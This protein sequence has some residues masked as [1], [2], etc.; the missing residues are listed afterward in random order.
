MNAES[1]REHSIGPVASFL[2]L[3]AGAFVGGATY[4][5]HCA[6]PV[7]LPSGK[8]MQTTDVLLHFVQTL[9][10]KH[11][12][13][14]CVSN[15]HLCAESQDLGTLG[16]LASTHSAH[17]AVELSFQAQPIYVIFLHLGTHIGNLYAGL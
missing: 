4:A 15:I 6:P 3:L 12:A 10:A 8:G 17:S 1:S 14:P 16:L 2:P 11:F 5:P 7:L 13:C 9:R